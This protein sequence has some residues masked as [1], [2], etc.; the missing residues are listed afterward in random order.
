MALNRNH[1]IGAGGIH[2]VAADNDLPLPY[3]CCTIDNPFKSGNVRLERTAAGK[4]GRDD[5]AGMY[6]PSG[7]F[8]SC[9][10]SRAAA[11]GRCRFMFRDCYNEPPQNQR[12]IA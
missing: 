5:M 7:Q 4:T 2:F 12:H 8:V 3:C 9:Y 11:G 6:M 10:Y 1:A